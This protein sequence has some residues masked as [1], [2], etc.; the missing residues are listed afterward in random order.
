MTWWRVQTADRDVTE[1]LD[2]EN[3]VSRNWTDES[4]EQHGVS[5]CASR[6]GLATYLAASGLPLGDGQWVMV[7]LTGRR[8]Y[9]QAHDAH[10]GEVLIEPDGVVAVHELDDAMWDLIGA[11]FDAA[12]A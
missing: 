1:L 3:W 12:Q 7:E 4:R 10:L 6:E 5:V 9:T 11:A 2:P 8:L